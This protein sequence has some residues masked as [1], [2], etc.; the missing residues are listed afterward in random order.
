M[1]T[2]TTVDIITRSVAV[3]AKQMFADKLQSVILYGSY[4]RGDY[5]TESDI[6]VMVLV[7][8]DVFELKKYNEEICGLASRISLENDITVS[9]YLKDYLTYNKYFHVMPYYQNV[10]NEGVV[11]NV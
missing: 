3:K 9:I 11:I 7:D 10:K 2:K 6:D 4:A 5:D 1:C 8:I